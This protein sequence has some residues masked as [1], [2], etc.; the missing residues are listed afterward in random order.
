MFA[1]FALFLLIGVAL[2]CFYSQYPAQAAMPTKGDEAF[3]TF[4]VDHMGIGFRGLI[5]AAV[6]GGHDVELVQLVQFIGQLADERLART[7][8]ADKS[9]IASRCAW[10]AC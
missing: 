5:L 3:M 4:V 10:P 1:Q 7:L 6:L 2:A 8:A 9:T